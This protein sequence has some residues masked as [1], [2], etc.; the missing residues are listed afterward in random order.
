MH[1]M[2]SSMVLNFVNVF[3]GG[4]RMRGNFVIAWKLIASRSAFFNWA[5]KE[6]KLVS[7]WQVVMS[8]V[9]VHL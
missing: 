3:W 8:F 5:A 6:R 7:S 4:G 1:I 2:T 9:R